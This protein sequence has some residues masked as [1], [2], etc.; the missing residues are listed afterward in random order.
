[1]TIQASGIEVNNLFGYCISENYT[2]EQRYGHAQY[3]VQKNYTLLLQY[4]VAQRKSTFTHHLMH[5]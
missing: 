5:S 3:L 1:L 4:Q 2:K